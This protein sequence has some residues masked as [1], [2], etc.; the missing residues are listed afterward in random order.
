MAEDNEY[1]DLGDIYEID[2]YLYYHKFGDKFRYRYENHQATAEDL[3]ITATQLNHHFLW[4][5]CDTF[6]FINCICLL[7]ERK[8]TCT[9]VKHLS[10][11]LCISFLISS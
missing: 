3:R 9:P 11:S 8:A 10:C 4:A 2:G 1:R 7:F 5:N 6:T